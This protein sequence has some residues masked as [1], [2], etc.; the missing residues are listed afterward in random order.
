[1]LRMLTLAGGLAGAMGLSQFPAL[2]QQYMQRLGGAVDEL[3]LIVSTYEDDAAA[4]GETVEAYIAGLS[5]EGPR[6]KVQA[7]N[8]TAQIARY[9]VLRE[10]LEALEGAGPFMRARLAAHMGDRGVAEQAYDNFKPAVPMNFEGAVFA[11]TGFFAGWA[12]LTMLFATLSRVLRLIVSPFRRRT[13][14]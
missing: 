6:A 5:Q 2:S 8:M 12:G 9:G 14:S 7:A 4:S 11:G 10:A 1:M 3:R 13:A